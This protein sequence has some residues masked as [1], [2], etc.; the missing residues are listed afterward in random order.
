M[1]KAFLILLCTSLVILL[2]AL[3]INPAV[4][5]VAKRQLKAIFKE[6]DVSIGSCYLNPVRQLSLY[7]ISIT[8][9]K[10]YAFLVKEAR[11]EYRISSILRGE[12]PKVSLKDATISITL[13][14]KNITAFSDY[15]NPGPKGALLVK[16]V[17]LSNCNLDLKAK[18][19]TVNGVVSLQVNLI[20]KTVDY[21]DIKIDSLGIQDLNVRTISFAAAQ[22]SSEGR[23]G[24]RQIK[25]NKLN[26]SDIKSQV[27]LSGKEL[28]LENVRAK[29]YEGDIGGS[30]KLKLDHD[31]S[32][33]AVLS[34][35][36]VDIA[37]V[38]DDFDLKE[39][40]EMTGRLSGDSAFKGKGPSIEILNG[41]LSSLGSGGMLIIKDTR[42]LENMARD[43]NQSL[44]LLVE[45]FR[46]YHY[47]IGTI[48][49]SLDNGNLILEIA[50]DGE[51]GKRTIN[52]V[53]HDVRFTKE[54]T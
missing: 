33:D 22:G 44:D 47:N 28:F 41:T 12:I 39:K 26:I 18:D 46:D 54:G 1:K 34:I 17:G 6:S 23:F 24:I 48:K 25:Y 9:K 11:V 7:D 16:S 51:K 45:N 32:Y 5:F 29:A 36:D 40:F 31:F 20:D 49:L 38:I 27:M 21:L 53:L 35:T 14:Q 15:L 52:I 37:R 3:L 2:T 50:L 42:F 8:H 10:A 13:P 43:T 30:V 4:T 19:I